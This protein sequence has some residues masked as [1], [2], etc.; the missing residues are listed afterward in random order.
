MYNDN[1]NL[2]LWEVRLTFAIQKQQYNRLLYNCVLKS[3][4]T[5]ANSVDKTEFAVIAI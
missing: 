2:S 4:T 3:K 1:N 5:L